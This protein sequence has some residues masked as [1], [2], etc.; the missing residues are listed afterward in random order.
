MT[1]PSSTRGCITST[2][3][4]PQATYFVLPMMLFATS[5][6]CGEKKY[7]FP[8]SGSLAR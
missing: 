7:S 8:S 5:E 3:S 2:R 1:T 4:V 6:T